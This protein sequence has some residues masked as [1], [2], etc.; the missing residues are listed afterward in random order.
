[1]GALPGGGGA[2]IRV[3]NDSTVT[4]FVEF[5]AGS[6]TA[7]VATSAPLLA[8]TSELFTV[9]PNITHIAAIAASGSGTVYATPGQGG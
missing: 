2:T 4:V 5:G 7:A 3:V 9:G 1:M 6:A 8:G